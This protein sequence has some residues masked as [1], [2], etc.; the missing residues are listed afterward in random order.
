MLPEGFCH[1]PSRQC[2][3]LPLSTLLSRASLHTVWFMASTARTPF[4]G[5]LQH[6]ADLPWVLSTSFTCQLSRTNLSSSNLSSTP[7][8]QLC[9]LLSIGQAG[10]IAASKE[11]HFRVDFLI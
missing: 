10:S 2:R 9:R 8:A 5:Q 6:S 3:M 4:A 1:L 7:R 11:P